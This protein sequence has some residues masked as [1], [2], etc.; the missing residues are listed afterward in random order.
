MSV[1]RCNGTADNGMV[2]AIRKGSTQDGSVRRTLVLF[3]GCTFSCLWCPDPELQSYAPELRFHEE[4]CVRCGNCV[5]TCSIEAAREDGMKEND[6][7]Y[8]IDREICIVCGACVSGCAGQAREIVGKCMSVSEVMEHIIPDVPLFKKSGGGVTFSGGEPLMQINFLD[9]LLKA[10]KDL[11]IHTTVDTSGYIPWEFLDRVRSRIDLFHFDLKLMDEKR[12]VQ[13]TGLP[14]GIILRNLET[15]SQFGHK[16]I[17]HV[18][19]IP[20]IT[21]DAENLSAIIL[22]ASRLP[23]LEGVALIPYRQMAKEK[24]VSLGRPYQPASQSFS[25]GKRLSEIV[26]QFQ[27]GGLAAFVLDVSQAE[28]IQ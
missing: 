14:N 6:S 8:T 24:Y 27:A 2:Y 10:C 18:P 15:L 7:H 11:D 23:H 22:F 26:S 19:V 1:G 21:D 4:R 5:S 12:H 13:F 9:Q 20:G 3:K 25:N 17:L 16:I 28:Q